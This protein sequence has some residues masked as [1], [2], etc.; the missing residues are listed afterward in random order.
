MNFGNYSIITKKDAEIIIKDP[1]I[2][3]NYSGTLKKNIKK[4]GNIN[5]VRGKRYFGPSKMPLF[6]LIGLSFSIIAVFKMNVFVRSALLL[7]LLTYL[8]PYLGI[9]SPTLQFFLVLFN[10]LIYLISRK[11]NDDKIKKIDSMLKDINKLTH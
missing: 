9:I 10:I 7:V 2:V 8:Q 6:K 5:C 3:F 4:L 11:S 1:T